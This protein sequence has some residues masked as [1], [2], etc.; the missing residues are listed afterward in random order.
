MHR[1]LYDRGPR[2]AHKPIKFVI[3]DVWIRRFLCQR[4]QML[5]TSCC[6]I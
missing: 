2:S 1:G 6:L 4:R 5:M 3:I